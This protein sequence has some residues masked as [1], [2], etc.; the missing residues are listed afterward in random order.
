MYPEYHKVY[1]MMRDSSGSYDR[2]KALPEHVLIEIGADHTVK[3][4]G[5]T[6]CS[7]SKVRVS[8][9]VICIGSHPDLS[10]LGPLAATD[11]GLRPNQPIDCKVNPIAIDTTTHESV[12]Q[13][14]LYALGPLVGENFVRFLQGGAL[15]ITSHLAKLRANN[16][17]RSRR[18]GEQEQ[19][20][21]DIQLKYEQEVF[22]P[23][24]PAEL[25]SF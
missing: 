22:T 20:E 7:N 8:N 19:A 9:V 18:K 6:A 21:E 5:P 16:K 23:E 11:L 14:G 10:F 25:I 3:I 15:A 1:Q 12:H 17:W 2:Y 13:P 4:Q 24:D